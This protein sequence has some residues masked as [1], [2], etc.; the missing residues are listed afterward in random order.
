LSSFLDLC[1]FFF[2][3]FGDLEFVALGLVWERL[4]N[5]LSLISLYFS[6]ISCTLFCGL[7]MVYYFSLFYI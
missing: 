3:L 5:F 7:P 6:F 1:S 4:K 2:L